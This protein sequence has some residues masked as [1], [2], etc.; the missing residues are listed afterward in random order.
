VEVFVDGSASET[1]SLGG[2]NWQKATIALPGDS[3]G[4]FHQIDLRVKPDNGDAVDRGRS[5]VEVG[6]WEIISK[7]NG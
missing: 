3:T 1:I 2:R 4:R 6:T 5:A 7:P